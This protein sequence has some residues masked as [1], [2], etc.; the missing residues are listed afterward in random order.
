M[1]SYPFIRARCFFLFHVRP[2]HG[3][4]GN[5]SQLYYLGN[6]QGNCLEMVISFMMCLVFVPLS[7]L[8][9]PCS[10]DSNLLVP[11]RPTEPCCWWLVVSSCPVLS[12]HVTPPCVHRPRTHQ[13]RGVH[14]ILVSQPTKVAPRSSSS[15]SSSPIPRRRRSD[16]SRQLMPRRRSPPL[17]VS[18][19]YS[20]PREEGPRTAVINHRR[21]RR[22]RI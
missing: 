12:R 11:Q 9:Y 3:A 4:C 15:S 14:Q 20:P 7:P 1:D 17:L 6:F 13:C 5:P 19:H 21:R 2:R 22:R 8:T 18:R 16:I 10:Y